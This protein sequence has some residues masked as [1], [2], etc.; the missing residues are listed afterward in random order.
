MGANAFAL[1]KVPGFEATDYALLHGRVVW[2]G[3]H[4]ATDHPRNL[5]APWWPALPAVHVG[6][7]S[8]VAL[9]VGA[10]LCQTQVLPWLAQQQPLG[11]LLPWLQG[12]ALPFPLEGARGRLVTLQ[13]ALRSADLAAI[14]AASIA[15]LGLG[16]GLTPS[17]DDLVGGVWFA[18]RLL[19]QP[20]AHAA[21]AKPFDAARESILDAAATRTNRISAALLQDTL[22][23]AS[24]RVLHEAAAAIAAQDRPDTVAACTR[25]VQLGA[26]S[27]A[28][29]LAGLL[30]ALT[31]FPIPSDPA[32]P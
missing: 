26:S 9:Q 27:G 6:P 16:P 25:L 32:L 29:M 7:H 12:G 18:L 14:A 23:G 15:L 22:D 30:T 11:G 4:A 1:Q 24:Y 28:D 2:V 19:I 10:H 3:E 5:H 13:A 8:P 17:G 31:E 20:Q 21:L